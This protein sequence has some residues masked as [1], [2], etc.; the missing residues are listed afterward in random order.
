MYKQMFT[1]L[2][3]YIS[4]KSRVDSLITLEG[5]LNSQTT[6]VTSIPNFEFLLGLYTIIELLVITR[7]RRKIPIQDKKYVK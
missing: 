1:F 5:A 2:E 3:E 4:R 7:F 6:D